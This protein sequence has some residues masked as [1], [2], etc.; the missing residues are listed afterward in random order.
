MKI[1]PEMQT[2]LFKWTECFL[3]KLTLM[4]Q[5]IKQG[6]YMLFICEL[7]RTFFCS[8]IVDLQI[9]TYKI[10][11]V[12]SVVLS[13]YWN[14][15]PFLLICCASYQLTNILHRQKNRL[16]C[17]ILLLSS[18]VNWKLCITF[19]YMLLTYITLKSKYSIMFLFLPLLTPD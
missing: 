13:L 14:I 18:D 11:I 12:I 3:E 7:K 10:D 19:K 15:I 2:Q 17:C 9:S 1:A 4:K 16:T 8:H 6:L 5:L